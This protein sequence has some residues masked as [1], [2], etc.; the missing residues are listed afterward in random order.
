MQVSIIVETL[1][2]S[3][4]SFGGEILPVFT[5]AQK[6]EQFMLQLSES[7]WERPNNV[8]LVV[9]DTTLGKIRLNVMKRRSRINKY[10]VDP[11]RFDSPVITEKSKSLF[12]QEP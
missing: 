1:R 2:M 3:P 4:L 7:D 5:T 8:E 10:V 9:I 11:P 12:E 6:A